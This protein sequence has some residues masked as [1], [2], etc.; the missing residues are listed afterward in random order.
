MKSDE[1][2]KFLK[3]YEERLNNNYVFD[4]NKELIQYCRSDVDILRRSII[5]FKDFIKLVNIDPLRCIPIASVCMSI[6]IIYSN[7]M[8]KNTIP[9][10][11]EY[12]KSD[13]FSS[14]PIMWLDY[15]AYKNKIQ[16]QHALNGGEKQSTNNQTYKVDGYCKENNTVYDSYGCF[17]HGCPICY[18]SN[19]ISNKNKKDIGT[20]N[21]NT[22]E[23]IE[24]IKRA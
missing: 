19:I 1:Q 22:N 10:V 6:C 9:V 5:K 13:N 16:I 3:W 4:F 12:T 14:T 7:Y 17:W 2:E 8:P 21:K 18:K 24:I 23:K 11:S 20:L 15:I